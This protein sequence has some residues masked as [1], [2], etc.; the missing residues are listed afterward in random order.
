MILG[1]GMSAL[2]HE[3]EDLL[4]NC[5]SVRVPVYMLLKTD[6]VYQLE[7]C[8]KNLVAL[9]QDISSVRIDPFL[10]AQPFRRAVRDTLRIRVPAILVT[11]FGQGTRLFDRVVG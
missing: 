4:S 10:E 3:P 5:P 2:F 1:K 8:M 11:V 6:R 7:P 9:I